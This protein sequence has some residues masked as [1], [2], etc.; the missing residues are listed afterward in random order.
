M[1]SGVRREAV[2]RSVEGPVAQLNKVPHTAAKTQQR[3][4]DSPGH[5][6][7]RRRVAEGKTVPEAVRSLKRHLAN[8]VYRRLLDDAEARARGELGSGVRGGHG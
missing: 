5:A 1:K 7:I 6:Y 8:A 4:P 2:R 3:M